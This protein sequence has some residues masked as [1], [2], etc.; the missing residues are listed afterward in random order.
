MAFGGIRGFP[1]IMLHCTRDVTVSSACIEDYMVAHQYITQIIYF[2]DYTRNSPIHHSVENKVYQVGINVCS[3]QQILDS[4]MTQLCHQFC[5][6]LCLVYRSRQL[7]CD[8][9]NVKTLK[10]ML[11][12]CHLVSPA[13]ICEDCSSYDDKVEGGGLFV[14]WKLV[15]RC[16]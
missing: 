1:T 2:T 11:N 10:H 3:K 9:L 15:E 13:S 14:W 12:H 8:A 6:K 5:A 4:V 7:T 16:S